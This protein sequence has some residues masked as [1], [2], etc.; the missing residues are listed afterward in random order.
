MA[1]P[2]LA[3]FVLLLAAVSSIRMILHLNRVEGPKCFYQSLSKDHSNLASGEKYFLQLDSY[4]NQKYRIDIMQQVGDSW[5]EVATKESSKIVETFNKLATAEGTHMFCVSN[6]EEETLKIKLDI[7]TGL[8]LGNLDHLP[9]LNDQE[10]LH[11]EIDWMERQ[12][13]KLFESLNRL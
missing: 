13:D 12:K 11:R 5:K 8:E 4:G 6:V 3:A 9:N 7:M 10:N 1:Y 2:R